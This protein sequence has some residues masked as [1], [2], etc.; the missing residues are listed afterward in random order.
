[1]HTLKKKLKT[2][3]L[4]EH[5]KEKCVKLNESILGKRKLSKRVIFDDDVINDFP[6][7]NTNCFGTKFL[8][9]SK[10]KA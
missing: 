4:D 1:M 9:S 6:T 10:L 8:A 3:H 7:G 5:V 2:S